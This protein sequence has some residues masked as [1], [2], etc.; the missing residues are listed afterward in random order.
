[1]YKKIGMGPV[2]RKHS[3]VEMRKPSEQQGKMA[4]KQD[5]ETQVFPELPTRAPW[6]FLQER[7]SGRKG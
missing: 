1:M 2:I 5:D 4:P 6:N 7:K 3:Q